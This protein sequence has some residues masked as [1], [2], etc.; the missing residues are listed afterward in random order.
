MHVSNSISLAS[1]A[2][3]PATVLADEDQRAKVSN[4]ES[5]VSSTNSSTVFMNST[6]SPPVFIEACCGSAR[7]S[8]ELKTRGF[9]P[10]PVDWINNRHKSALPVVKLDH[11]KLTF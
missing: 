7:L 2:K 3:V 9:W 5:R 1:D 4:S 6:K 8:F 10:I 11:R